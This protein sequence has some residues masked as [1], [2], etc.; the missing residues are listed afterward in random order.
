MTETQFRVKYSELIGHYQFIEIHLKEICA[1]LLADK[2]RGW[3]KRLDDYETDTMGEMIRK[4]RTIQ[5]QKKVEFFSSENFEELEALRK[6][7]NF[8]IH[9]CFIDYVHVSFKKNG[10]IKH[11]EHAKWII[12]DFFN[13]QEWNEKLVEIGGSIS[14]AK[15]SSQI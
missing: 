14:K 1:E 4:L 5:A 11:P 3:F 7:R 12:D 9:L 10:D 15:S 6:R 8:W 2:D 13:A